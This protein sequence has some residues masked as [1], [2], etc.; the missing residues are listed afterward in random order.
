MASSPL[1]LSAT[2]NEQY[3]IGVDWRYCDRRG[4]VSGRS[5]L[6]ISACARMSII[7]QQI[8]G[9]VVRSE[10]GRNRSP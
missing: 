4:G 3:Q 1:F 7:P 2:R 9:I 8:G 6:G 5:A 10:A